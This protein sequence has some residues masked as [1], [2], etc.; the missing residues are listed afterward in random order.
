[1]NEGNSSRR[2]RV[3]AK[4]ALVFDVLALTM[5]A[6]GERVVKLV[7]TTEV[8]RTVVNL[9]DGTVTQGSVATGV[10]GADT[11]LYRAVGSGRRVGSAS[12]TGRSRPQHLPDGN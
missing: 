3:A 5:S 8:T 4:G 11:L 1:M 9:A 6:Y 10:G 7:D 12:G 2:W